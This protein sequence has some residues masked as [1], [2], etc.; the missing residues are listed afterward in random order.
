M[1]PQT[2]FIQLIYILYTLQTTQNKIHTAIFIMITGIYT[3]RRLGQMIT[4]TLKRLL[5]KI[6]QVL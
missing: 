1:L 2:F 3:V 6:I 4:H 5:L